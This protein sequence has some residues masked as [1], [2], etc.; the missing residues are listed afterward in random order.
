MWQPC[1]IYVYLSRKW[2]PTPPPP[3]HPL[4]PSASPQLS[5]W[6]DLLEVMMLCFPLPRVP[7]PLPKGC[8]KVWSNR[9]FGIAHRVQHTF[10]IPWHLAVQV[11]SLS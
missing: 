3:P 6:L 11:P 9:L 8:F 10:G 1:I 4:P 5:M 7:S 2:P